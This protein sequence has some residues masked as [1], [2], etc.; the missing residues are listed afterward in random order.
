MSLPHFIHDLCHHGRVVFG[1]ILNQDTP[2]LQVEL[3]GL[4]RRWRAHAPGEAPELRIDAAIWAAE[5]LYRCCRLARDL[6]VAP[7][8]AFGAAIGSGQQTAAVIW[9]VDLLL[10]QLPNLHRL[11]PQLRADHPLRELLAGLGGDWPLSSVGLPG[12]EVEAPAL[13]VVAA[14]P[15]LRQIYIDRVIHWADQARHDV[16]WVQREVAAI[17]ESPHSTMTTP[18]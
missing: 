10:Q 5:T 16:S 18:S 12:V 17:L 11:V 14:H 7:A 13:E 15:A 6:E 8:V 9:S 1:E 2:D 4:D 3:E